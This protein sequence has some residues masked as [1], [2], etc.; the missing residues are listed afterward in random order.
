MPAVVLYEVYKKLKSFSGEDAAIG[1]SAQL[2]R[3]GAV[4][5]TEAL[6]LSA[7]DLSLAHKLAMADA[8]VLATARAAGA[9]LVTLDAD[10]EGLPGATVLR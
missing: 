5:L 9:E 1:A 10:F 7:A 8:M 6:A 3:A 2:A 4:P